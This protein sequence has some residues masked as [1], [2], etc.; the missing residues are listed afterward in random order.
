MKNRKSGREKLHAKIEDLTDSQI[1]QLLSYVKSI[2]KN[3]VERQAPE[4]VEDELLV[5]LSAAVE[6]RRARQVFEWEST[7][8]RAE[9]RST[10]L[11]QTIQ[12]FRI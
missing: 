7:R 1:E 5:S 8:R 3:R 10:R 4:T 12:E 9:A 11:T 6:N 2:E